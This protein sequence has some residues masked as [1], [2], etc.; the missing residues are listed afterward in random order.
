MLRTAWGWQ[1]PCPH[2]GLSP[3]ASEM[4]HPG[5]QARCVAGCAGFQARPWW[6]PSTSAAAE[7]RASTIPHCPPRTASPAPQ[8]L[9]SGRCHGNREPRSWQPE[10]PP[11]GVPGRGWGGGC[12][13][14][15]QANLLFPGLLPARDQPWAGVGAANRMGSQSQVGRGQAGLRPLVL[16]HQHVA[17]PHQPRAQAAGGQRGS[18]VTEALPPTGANG[19]LRFPSEP[20]GPQSQRGKSPTFHFP[21]PLSAPASHPSLWPHTPF[22]HRLSLGSSGPQHAHLEVGA[23]PRAVEA[24]E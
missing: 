4:Q 9:I 21:L 18:W 24:T 16:T 10:E 14:R 6:G 13:G 19:A 20:S 22:S 15:R 17:C 1:G 2:S 12:G 8:S 7:F 3:S 5:R 11:R 23:R